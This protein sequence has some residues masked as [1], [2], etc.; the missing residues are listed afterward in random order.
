MAPA[1]VFPGGQR[2]QSVTVPLIAPNTK[3]LPR[4][5]QLDLSLKR[6]FRVRT[7]E[8]V[9]DLTVFNVTNSSVV[10]NEIQTF[11]ASL[12][13]PTEIMS[14]RLPRIGLQMRF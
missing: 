12:G 6:T 4:W 5:T 1:S 7:I 13:T 10:L 2:T 3:Y 14:A 9:G 11:G 8:L